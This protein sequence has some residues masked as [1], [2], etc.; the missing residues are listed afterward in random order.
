MSRLCNLA[1]S[2]LTQRVKKSPE[3]I[4]VHSAI[5]SLLRPLMF[6]LTSLCL[7]AFLNMNLQSLTECL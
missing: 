7:F 1:A 5:T 4:F 3:L 2:V 6:V